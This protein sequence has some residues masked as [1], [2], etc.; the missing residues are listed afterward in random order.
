MRRRKE[1][2]PDWSA[3]PEEFIY[4]RPAGEKFG[5]GMTVQGKE[6]I[7]DSLVPNDLVL[8]RATYEELVRRQDAVAVSCW[9]QEFERDRL[10]NPR[11]W[12]ME[13]GQMLFQLFHFFDLLGERNIAPFNSRSVTYC[14]PQ[15]LPD[16]SDLPPDLS[17]IIEPAER[18]GVADDLFVDTLTAEQVEEIALLAERLKCKRQGSLLQEWLDVHDP[19]KQSAA[20]HVY[21]LTARFNELD[22]DW[23]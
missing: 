2:P 3:L 1:H 18:Y 4:L 22:L 21:W 10:K 19:L 8:L 6:R 14:P 5:M 20:M 11:P 23:D 16:W 9:I 13:A 15:E 17:Y 12:K 7:I